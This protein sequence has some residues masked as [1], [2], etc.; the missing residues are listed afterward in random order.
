MSVCRPHDC[1]RG[2][3]SD[4]RG[5]WVVSAPH[6]KI[7]IALACIS[8]IGLRPASAQVA[9][10]VLGSRRL[11]SER[12]VFS[13]ILWEVRYGAAKA[14]TA[15]KTSCFARQ[16]SLCIANLPTC[17][18]SSSFHVSMRSAKPPNGFI[19]R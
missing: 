17:T 8:S 1:L 7:S 10:G 9:F 12:P 15:T 4:A 3:K 19:S 2:L 16:P 11:G 13:A 5:E 14:F 6:Q 18:F